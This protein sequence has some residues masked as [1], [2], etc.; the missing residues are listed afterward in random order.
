MKPYPLV[1]LVLLLAAL[2]VAGP[3]IGQDVTNV[4]IVNESALPPE[5]LADALATKALLTDFDPKLLRR[6][7]ELAPRD[8]LYWYLSAATH[9]SYVLGTRG[10]V[11]FEKI[12]P[13]YRALLERAL[14]VDPNYIPALYAYVL[15]KAT[16]GQRMEGLQRLASLDSDNAKPYYLMAVES[17]REASKTCRWNC[18]TQSYTMS[19]EKWQSVLD[20]IRQGN[21]RS[22]FRADA[23]RL[24]STADV[25]ARA[26]SKALSRADLAT[27]IVLVVGNLRSDHGDA[28]LSFGTSPLLRQLAHQVHWE[29]GQAYKQGRRADA[30]DMLSVVKEL[31][32][33]Y[34]ASE[35]RGVL[36]LAA[37][38]TVWLI[39]AFK[40]EDIYEAAGDKAALRSLAAETAKWK[41]ANKRA[42]ELFQE[43]SEYDISLSE[44]KQRR[45]REQAEVAKV[46]QGLGLSRAPAV[47]R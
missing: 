3:C 40:E 24:L 12:R 38:S 44:W 9:Y 31:G 47:L 28:P 20:L 4:R 2:G 21:Q 10:Y 34:A 27:A 8:P 13:A 32:A 41:A 19:R 45:D 30:L 1:L 15:T 29:A 33:K 22:V 26:G 43:S 23:L 5:R 14:A 35:P 25:R 18:G 11:P 16:Y 46:L 6:A 42:R 7:A 17:Y 37:G 36:Q 39:A